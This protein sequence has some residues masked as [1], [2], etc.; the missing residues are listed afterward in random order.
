RARSLQ[1][2]TTLLPDF[3]D[4]GRH[5]VEPVLLRDADAQTLHRFANGAFVIRHRNINTGC[6]FRIV[7]RHR[8]QEYRRIAH[9][10]RERARLI[11]RGCESNGSPARAAPVGR[12]DADS[13]GE[14]R[15]LADRAPVS[16]PV[17]PRQSCAATAA[18]EPPDEPPGVSGV[19]ESLRRQGE[20][21]GPHS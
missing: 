19:L 12:L 17:A 2:G 14:R 7:T 13:A 6:V 10:P 4:F 1:P 15:R 16:V 21:T 11:E 20:C 5:A 3:I 18:A 9:A 8:A